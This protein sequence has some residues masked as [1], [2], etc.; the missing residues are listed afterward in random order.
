MPMWILSYPSPTAIISRCPQCMGFSSR[1][2]QN[3][4]EVGLVAVAMF[5]VGMSV[6]TSIVAAP[7][8]KTYC[9]FSKLSMDSDFGP[10]KLHSRARCS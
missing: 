4:G 1:P 5:L 7:R 6:W 3:S 9:I 2:P 10:D 8:Q